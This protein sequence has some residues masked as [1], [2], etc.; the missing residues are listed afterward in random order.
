MTDRR[1][2]SRRKLLWATATIGAAASTGSGAAAVM[3]DSESSRAE[4]AAGILE[5]DS[6]WGN[7]D[8]DGGGSSI[9]LSEPEGRETLELAVSGNP[10]YVWF[11][12]QCKQ[13]TDDEDTLMVRFGLETDGGQV[14]WFDGFEDD[15]LSLRAARELLGEGYFL[16]EIDPNASRNL[17]V[18]WQTG[19]LM[20]DLD[21][22]LDFGLYA[23]QTR[24]VMNTESVGPTWQCDPCGSPSGSPS[25][26]K[27]ISWV[28]F[29]TPDDISPQDVT[30]EFEDGGR[31]VV[32]TEMPTGV[33]IGAVLLKSGQYLDVFYVDSV[34]DVIDERFTSGDGTER[35]EQQKNAF[36]TSG[37]PPRSNDDPCPESNWIKY[38]VDEDR[39]YS[40][41]DGGDT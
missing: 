7:T 9:T 8:D 23:T 17:V 31:T 38:D 19:T 15:F 21:V 6:F 14:E 13:C 20:T 3:T 36:P 16:G 2:L 33:D 32:V 10:S 25:E 39:W 24:H 4:F 27:A 28:G 34:D 1:A 5:I 35:H 40:S 22:T 30:L 26:S 12:T 37:S 29:C 11:R 18:E 41:D